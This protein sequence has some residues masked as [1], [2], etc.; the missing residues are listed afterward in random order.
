MKRSRNV[1]KD[2]AI[3]LLITIVL[4]GV[5]EL[6]LRWK[7]YYERTTIGK[8][9]LSEAEEQK[10]HERPRPVKKNPLLDIWEIEDPFVGYKPKSSFSYNGVLVTNSHGFRGPEFSVKKKTGV[11]RIVTLGD[12]VTFGL[13]GDPMCNWPSQLQR[14]LEAVGPGQYEVINGGVEGYSTWHVLQRLRYE[15][16]SLKPDMIIVLV[17]WNDLWAYDPNKEMQV[18]DPRVLQKMKDHWFNRVVLKS[19][20]M[21]WLT[22]QVFRL[23]KLGGDSPV[24]QLE[25]YRQFVPVASIDNYRKIVRVAKA[26]EIPWIVL[27]TQPSVAG[28][29][30]LEKYQHVMH[31]PAFAKTPELFIALWQRYSAAIRQVAEEEGAILI[32]MAELIRKDVRDSGRYFFDSAHM[33]CEG[34][35]ILG[36]KVVEELK[37]QG[38]WADTRKG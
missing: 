2:V 3:G 14:Q 35:E 17:G 28:S 1:W 19:Y 26:A 10:G 4:C 30:Q 9:L 13:I 18:G 38:V 31:F 37:A 16:V 29:D 27:G 23:V 24:N 6:S 5:A 32:D 36:R 7:V 20:V 12:S 21:K 11:F 8:R 15:V 33:Y 34:Y 25:H 22:K